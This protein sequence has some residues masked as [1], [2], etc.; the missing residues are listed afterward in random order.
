MQAAH[1]QD[2]FHSLEVGWFVAEVLSTRE[3]PGICLTLCR[4][5]RASFP[6][7]LAMGTLKTQPH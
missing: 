3:Q 6:E 2:V 5:T 4:A 1:L 7:S